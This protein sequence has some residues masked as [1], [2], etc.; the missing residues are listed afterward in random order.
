MD[1]SLVTTDLSLM[2]LFSEADL[3]VKLVMLGLMI[4]SV[5]SWAIIFEKLIL[6]KLVNRNAI[7]FYR[8]FWSSNI[9]DSMLPIGIQ[10]ITQW[11]KSSMLE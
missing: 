2:G 4:A 7:K 9:N 3:V 6:I 5:I 1:E 11:Q 8:D 10:E